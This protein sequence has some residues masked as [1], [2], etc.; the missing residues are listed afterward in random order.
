MCESS[1]LCS[2]SSLPVRI[3]L[4]PSFNRSPCV[5]RINSQGMRVNRPYK[6][7]NVRGERRMQTPTRT[8]SSRFV[9]R[10]FSKVRKDRY[11]LSLVFLFS[12]LKAIGYKQRVLRCR[13][14]RHCRGGVIGRTRGERG[15]TSLSK[16]LSVLF[17][18]P[19]SLPSISSATVSSCTP[20]SPSSSIDDST[21]TK[22]TSHLEACSLCILWSLNPN[23]MRHA[24]NKIR[25]Y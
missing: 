4:G 10:L 25:F 22:C 11:F 15:P 24:L 23:E 14:V 17:L 13:G 9:T 20:P 7:M 5:P 21:S 6:P 16:P 8:T 1:R 2:A 18:F 3:P 19:F 12:D